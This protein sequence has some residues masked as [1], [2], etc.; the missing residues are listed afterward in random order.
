MT[1]LT[2]ISK[3]RATRA[4]LYLVAEVVLEALA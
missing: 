2:L 3:Q 4:I 1:M